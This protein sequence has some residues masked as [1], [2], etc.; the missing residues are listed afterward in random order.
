MPGL[1]PVPTRLRV[2]ILAWLPG[3]NQQ[4][5]VTTHTRTTVS[6]IHRV[7]CNDKELL[8]LMNQNVLRIENRDHV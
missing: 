8:Q 5:I 4:I 2:T 7:H 1:S 6:T 3:T